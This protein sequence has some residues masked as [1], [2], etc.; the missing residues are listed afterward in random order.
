MLT[1][2][3]WESL[4]VKY[5]V[6]QLEQG[7]NGTPHYQGYIECGKTRRFSHFK[8]ILARAHFEKAQADTDANE[9]YCT[10][11]EGRLDGPWSFGERQKPGK[12]NDL[13]KLRDCV[14]RGDSVTDI[15]SSEE[16][17]ETALRHPQALRLL[18]DTFSKPQKRDD[19]HVT[20]HYGPPGTGKSHCAAEDDAYIFDG[21]ANGFWLGYQGET[22]CIFDE[23]GGH[24]LKPMQLQRVCDKYPLTLNVKGGHMACKITKVDICSNYLPNQWWNEKTRYNELA[25]YRRIHEVHW[26]Y[27]FGKYRRYVTTDGSRDPMESAMQKFLSDKHAK[28]YNVNTKLVNE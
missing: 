2:E 17:A 26:H 4:G 11:E 1:D 24:C 23:F 12:R 20:L 7:E 5:A 13:I 18:N 21:D 25:I 8:S 15:L 6:W 14:K 27:E 3:K 10:K 19:I 28:E 22:H 9:A 16:V